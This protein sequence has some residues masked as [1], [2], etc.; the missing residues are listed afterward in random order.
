[1]KI[2]VLSSLL[3]IFTSFFIVSCD[4]DIDSIGE[5]IQPEID[6][7]IFEID[8]ISLTAKTVSIADYIFVQNDKALLGEL[9]DPVFGNLK[10]DFLA[11]YYCANE[12]FTLGYDDKATVDSVSL[13]F[14]FF[15]SDFMGDTI[16]P[17]SMS[18]YELTKDLEPNFYTNIDPLKY[19]DKKT[20]LGQRYFSFQE[21]NVNVYD[22][23][24]YRTTKIELDKAYGENLYKEWE[25]DNKVLKDSEGLRKIMKGIYVTTDF[26]KNGIFAFDDANSSVDVRV[27]YS[28]KLKKVN[29]PDKDSIINTA[30]R[31]P[32]AADA[33]K[34]NR[35]TN[36]SWNEL[37]SIQ[38]NNE[39]DKRTLIKSPAGVVTELTIPLAEI[40]KKAQDKTN[41]KDK[42]MVNSAVFKILGF[43]EE[44]KELSITERPNTLLFINKDSIDNFFLNK[45]K[46][47]GLTS[48]VMVRDTTNNSYNYSYQNTTAASSNNLSAT[49][50]HYLEQDK[51]DD[52]LDI[53]ELKFLLIPIDATVDSQSQISSI[54][55]SLSPSAAIFR[56]NEKHMK[57]S[58]A[59][60]K[61]QDVE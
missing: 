25:K 57:M 44:E 28:Y 49:I 10:A 23:V 61:H 15:K 48:I 24:T 39:S 14:Q 45:K 3:I 9:N 52:N 26:N 56:T 34:M 4:D 40:K 19:C 54:E 2:K 11:E 42:F 59:F 51:K 58:L 27:Y 31:L 8:N 47:D 53:Q 37:Q 43:T 6:D 60:S 35:V 1:M 41:S 36:T 12:K 17:M 5:T 22:G 32:I 33:I 16:S 20:I 29:E 55:N 50:N 13:Y 21:T 46:P 7:I 30:L 38:G 18:V